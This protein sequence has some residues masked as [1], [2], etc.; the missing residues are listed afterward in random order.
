MNVVT[1]PVLVGDVRLVRNGEE[2]ARSGCRGDARAVLFRRS[3]FHM[4][5]TIAAAQSRRSRVA[6]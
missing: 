5:E 1:H 3:R 4:L 2:M 6:F